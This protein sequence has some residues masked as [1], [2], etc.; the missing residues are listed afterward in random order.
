MSVP[1]EPTFE[2]QLAQLE[3]VVSELD[4]ED[5]PL[6]KAIN[7]YEKG[8]RLSLALNKTLAQ[9]QQRIEILT[10]TANGEMVPVPFEDN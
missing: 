8:V 4:A 5:L 3:Q 1:Q 9:A 2:E 6:E 7:A 10:Q